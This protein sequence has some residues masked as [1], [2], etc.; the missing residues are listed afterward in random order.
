[1]RV[2][3]PSARLAGALTMIRAAAADSG[4]DAAIEGSAVTGVLDVKVSVETPAAA[5]AR[6]VDALRAELGG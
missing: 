4:I 3:F 2:A 6:F 5:V 1:V